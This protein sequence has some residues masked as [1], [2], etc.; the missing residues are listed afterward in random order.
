M[1]VRYMGS[2]TPGGENED[3]EGVEGPRTGMD[4]MGGGSISGAPS[5]CALN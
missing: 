5:V 4:W 1:C 3:I 2:N